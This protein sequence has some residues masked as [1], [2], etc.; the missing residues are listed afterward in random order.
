M[1]GVE[2]PVMVKPAPETLAWEMLMLAEP[3]LV[4]VTVEEPD[5]PTL[6]VLKLTAPGFAVRLPCTPKPLSGI[7]SVELLALL[8]MVMEPEA[9]PAVVGANC[10]EKFTVWLA[11]T[12]T[13]VESPETLKPA[14]VAEIDEM[15][16]L[17]LP[18][19]V[20]VMFCWPLLPTATLAK[21]T[22]AGLAPRVELVATPVPERA[23]VCGEFGALS[24]K[25]M[26]PEAAPFDVGVN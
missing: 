15:V 11:A 21:D 14:P 25:L 19:L 9:A 16:A 17:A 22:E 4:K 20:R 3:E 12:V 5:E 23:R 1:A 2:R 18:E 8:L 13:G 26:L 7:E 24:V 6:T 10:A